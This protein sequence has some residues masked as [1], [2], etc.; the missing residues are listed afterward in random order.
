MNLN[1]LKTMKNIV[2][3]IA[4]IVLFA[5]IA[6]GQDRLHV[7]K[8]HYLAGNGIMLPVPDGYEWSPEEQAFVHPTVFVESPFEY[9]FPTC[10]EQKMLL[11]QAFDRAYS[12]GRDPEVSFFLNYYIENC[13]TEERTPRPLQPAVLEH[14]T[15]EYYAYMYREVMEDFRRNNP[16]QSFVK[17]YK[18]R[19][20]RLFCYE[21][22]SFE[23]R[24]YRVEIPN[25][26]IRAR[27][28]CLD[29]VKK[30]HGPLLT[31]E[32]IQVTEE[33]DKVESAIGE[34]FADVKR[35]E[36]LRSVGRVV[37]SV[38]AIGYADYLMKTLDDDE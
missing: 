2:L 34:A 26:L 18:G 12:E 10:N 11:T 32:S 24:T 1:R 9:A 15:E 14:F 38:A 8:D 33:E 37:A 6:Y 5:S 30:I 17:E 28:A 27:R 7:V 21:V 4:A 29:A 35:G 3:T 22:I 20:N 25:E 13:R 36:R 16:G 23:A 19:Q 31:A